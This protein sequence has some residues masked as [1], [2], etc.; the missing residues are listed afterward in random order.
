MAE[1]QEFV[2]TRVLSRSAGRLLI[3]RLPAHHARSGRKLS[4]CQTGHY[5]WDALLAGAAEPGEFCASQ[6]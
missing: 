2:S 5:T 3:M 4:F 1:P 6:S